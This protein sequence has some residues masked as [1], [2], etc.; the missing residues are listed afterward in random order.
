MMRATLRAGAGA[1]VLSLSVLVPLAWGAAGAGPLAVVQDA[2]GQVVAILSQPDQ[3][4]TEPFQEKLKAVWTVVEK[5]FADQ[6]MVRR[7]AGSHWKSLDPEQ[8]KELTVL[9]TKLLWRSYLGRLRE[10]ENQKISYTKEMID[11]DYAE[12]ESQIVHRGEKIPLN[13][14]LIRLDGRWLI[15]DMVI[16]GMSLVANYR[17]QFNQIINREGYPG[18]V[19]RLRKKLDEV[20]NREPSNGAPPKLDKD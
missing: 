5:N 2:V 15:Y 18:L 12:V 17:R 4:S 1:V 6:E 11:G 20:E 7:T 10:F 14:K 8:R 9:F 3:G 16:D 13:Y 19:G